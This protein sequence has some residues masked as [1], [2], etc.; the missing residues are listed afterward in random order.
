MVHS[1][2]LGAEEAGKTKQHIPFVLCLICPQVHL[3][4]VKIGCRNC[5]MHVRKSHGTGAG[6]EAID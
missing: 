4:K 1:V 6:A 3:S 5:Q 2:A